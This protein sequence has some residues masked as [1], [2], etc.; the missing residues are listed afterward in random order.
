MND[1]NRHQLI[2]K[3]Q[4]WER[5][6]EKKYELLDKIIFIRRTQNSVKEVLMHVLLKKLFHNLLLKFEH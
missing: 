6:R 4:R 1:E 3:A 5:F 2:E